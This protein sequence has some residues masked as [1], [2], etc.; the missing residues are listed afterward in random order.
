MSCLHS[1]I[2][3]RPTNQHVFPLN[4]INSIEPGATRDWDKSKGRAQ[5]LCIITN[6]NKGSHLFKTTPTLSL[7]VVSDE[8]SSPIT[9]PLTLPSSSSLLGRRR[10]FNSE[11]VVSTESGTRENRTPIGLTPA[12]VLTL[13][14]E[15]L[16]PLCSPAGVADNLIGD[17]SC[18]GG[19]EGGKGDLVAGKL[20]SPSKVLS[21]TLVVSTTDRGESWRR[22]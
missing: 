1:K 16:S 5:H 4:F 9:E 8:L 13:S 2:Q 10:T 20:S 7:D 19:G 14:S 22:I 17:I 21:L 12:L 3:S 18:D 6:T 15:D 11:M